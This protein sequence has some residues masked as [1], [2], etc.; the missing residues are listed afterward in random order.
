MLYVE[1]VILNRAVVNPRKNPSETGKRQ[2]L[3]G[4]VTEARLHH[5]KGGSNGTTEHNLA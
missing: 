4:V 3:G 1:K 5:H 2:V